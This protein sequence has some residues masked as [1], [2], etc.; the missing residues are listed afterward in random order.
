M[1]VLILEKVDML[2][3]HG[4]TTTSS[5]RGRSMS[6]SLL[7]HRFVFVGYLYVSQKFEVGMTTFRIEQP[8]E[9]LRCSHC[10]S[11]EVWA[12]GGVYRSFH[13]LPIGSKPTF[14]E[15]KVPR[16][17]CFDCDTVRQVKISF[18]EPKKHYTRSLER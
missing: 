11:S 18:A 6:T 4:V 3:F 17:R 8:R 12:Q 13:A 9:K 7:Y 14:V 1:R 10:G 15:L 5:L 16:V 2:A